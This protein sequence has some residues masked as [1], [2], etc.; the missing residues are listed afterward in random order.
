MAKSSATL[1]TTLAGLNATAK[2]LDEGCMR[3]VTDNYMSLKTQVRELTKNIDAAKVD[4]DEIYAAL[5]FKTTESGVQSRKEYQQIH[6]QKER[7]K[8]ALQKGSHSEG[9]SK[10]L[11]AHLNNF[12]RAGLVA[13]EGADFDWCKLIEYKDVLF[14]PETFTSSKVTYFFSTGCDGK[15]FE[16]QTFWADIAEHYSTKLVRMESALTENHRW[17]GNKGVIDC[18]AELKNR[19]SSRRRI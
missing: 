8:T 2:N 18:L 15:E 19:T 9:H 14:N 17:V 5:Q 16:S 7:V 3:A 1:A 4:F 12:N 11:G 13:S 6:W 10:F